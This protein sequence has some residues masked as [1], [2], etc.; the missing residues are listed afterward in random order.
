MDQQVS[1]DAKKI[2]P[3]T[4]IHLLVGYVPRWIRSPNLQIA[5]S[6]FLILYR[7]QPQALVYLGYD[8]SSKDPEELQEAEDL[9]HEARPYIKNSLQ[10]LY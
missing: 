9:L 4:S 10:A 8:D 6:A 5:A 7:R 3:E 1:Y 2:L